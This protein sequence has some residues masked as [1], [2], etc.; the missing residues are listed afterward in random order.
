M[1]LIKRMYI[2][3]VCFALI[4]TVGMLSGCKKQETT[5]ENAT[6]VETNESKQEELENTEE[7]QQRAD[8][9][10]AAYIRNAI[11]LVVATD[12]ANKYK[13]NVKGGMFWTEEHKT[14]LRDKISEKLGMGKIKADDGN[15]YSIIPVPKEKGH[16]FYVY[17]LPPYTVVSLKTKDTDAMHSTGKIDNDLFLQNPEYLS[18]RF[19]IANYGQVQDVMTLEPVASLEGI[20]DG[21][22][23]VTLASDGENHVGWLNRGIDYGVK[24]AN[25]VKN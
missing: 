16:A 14:A 9:S 13:D 21:V 12:D 10:I 8:Q 15:E 6:K 24:S 20:E 3:V 18:K 25:G 19:P 1:K 22:A 23:A 2:L 5:E 7:T 11:C 4:T 17:L